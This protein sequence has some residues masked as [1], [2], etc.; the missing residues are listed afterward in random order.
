MA[1]TPKCP[2]CSKRG[3][4][5]D[6]LLAIIDETFGTVSGPAKEVFDELGCTD[7]D[8]GATSA[9]IQRFSEACNEVADCMGFDNEGGPGQSSHELWCWAEYRDDA[10]EQLRK[11][12]DDAT[13]ILEMLISE[14]PLCGAERNLLLRRRVESGWIYFTEDPSGEREQVAKSVRQLRPK[15]MISILEVGNWFNLHVLLEQIE[16]NGSETI[17]RLFNGEYPVISVQTE[18]PA[19]AKAVRDWVVEWAK[20]NKETD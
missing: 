4:G 6:H 13:V 12:L 7:S 8:E 11:R 1:C 3:D 10:L 17:E 18:I 15:R 14:D 9:D 20:K 2:H 19:L 16:W 5:C